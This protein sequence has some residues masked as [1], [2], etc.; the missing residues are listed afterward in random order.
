MKKLIVL[1]IAISFSI[2]GSGVALADKSVTNTLDRHAVWSK[3]GDDDNRI[4]ESTEAMDYSRGT[5]RRVS[6]ETVK[7]GMT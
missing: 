3:W 2:M 6:T 1:M 5:T 4:P 7:D